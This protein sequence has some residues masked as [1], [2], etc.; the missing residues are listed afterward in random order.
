MSQSNSLRAYD[1]AVALITGGASGIGRGLCEELAAQGCEVIVTDIQME[2]ATEVTDGINSSGGKAVARELNVADPMAFEQIVT[3]IFENRGRLDY[4]FNNAGI[5]PGGTHAHTTPEDWRQLLD[6]NVLGVMNGIY[7]AYQR[8]SDQGFG[9]IVSVA[10]GAGLMPSPFTLP[11]TA[12]KFAVVGLSTA[13]R[14]EAEFHGI[15]VSV[16]CPGAVRTPLLKRKA[17]KGVNHDKFMNMVD[18]MGPMEP[19]EFARRVLKAVKRNPPI[20]IVQNA[21]KIAYFLSRIF[22]GYIYR[23]N[24]KILL[25]IMD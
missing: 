2:L 19:N 11:Y 1:G 17:P 10:S 22:P 12:T 23:A 8:M 16:V 6:V 20:I 15:R 24:R 25:N 7:P 5:N 18:S 21:V 3:E 14:T 4:L 13:L 9:H